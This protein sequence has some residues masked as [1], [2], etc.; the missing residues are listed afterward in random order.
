MSSTR[1]AKHPRRPYFATSFHV[2]SQAA[3]SARGSCTHPRHR[4]SNTFTRIKS[5]N[6]HQLDKDKHVIY[7]AHPHQQRIKRQ[8]VLVH[9]S[10]SSRGPDLFK[11]KTTTNS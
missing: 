8:Y 11:K 7:S 9:H 2:P 1:Q 10:Q 5:N 4:H 6:R 3:C